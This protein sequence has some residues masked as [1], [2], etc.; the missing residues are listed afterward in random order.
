MKLLVLLFVF[1]SL[2]GNKPE[3]FLLNKYSQNMNISGWYMSEKLDGIRAYWD[4][5]QLKSKNGYK[6]NVPKWFIEDFPPFALDGELWTKRGDFENIQSIVLDDIPS[7]KWKE[8][9]Y[10]IFE[11]P[12]QNGNFTKRLQFANKWLTDKQIKHTHIIKRIKCKNREHLNNYLHYIEKLGG[13]GLIIKNPNL[14][15]FTGRS[16]EILKVKSFDDMEGEVIDINT[17]KGKFKDLMEV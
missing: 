10:Q 9:T 3:L 11:V 13:E 1:T 15:Y 17:G 5:K 2:F 16:V 12:D 4:G 6:I 14:S 8:I 7:K